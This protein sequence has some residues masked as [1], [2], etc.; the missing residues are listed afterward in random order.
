M[1]FAGNTFA[2]NAFCAD[3]GIFSNFPIFPF[4]GRVL[5]FVMSLNLQTDFDLAFNSMIGFPI[6]LNTESDFNLSIN[7]QTDFDVDITKSLE[8]QLIR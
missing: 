7:S 4:N 1:S 5:N 3:D 2:G 6:F 8:Y